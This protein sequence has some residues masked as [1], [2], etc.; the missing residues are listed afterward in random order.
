MSNLT[1]LM[2]RSST[3]LYHVCYCV[4]GDFH[5]STLTK[6]QFQFSDFYPGCSVVTKLAYDITLAECLKVPKCRYH[7]SEDSN[8]FSNIVA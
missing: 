6:I 2:Q 3:A 5:V 1:I 7:C 8:A 4:P